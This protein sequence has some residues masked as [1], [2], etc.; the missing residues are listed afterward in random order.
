M[1]TSYLTNLILIVVVGLLYWLNA[2]EA[3]DGKTTTTLSQVSTKSIDNI[4][5]SQSKRDDIILA[6]QGE[7]WQLTHPI[8]THANPT[9]INLL[10]SLLSSHTYRQ[11]TVSEQ[12]N[13][14]QFGFNN[15]STRLQLADQL[16]VFGGVEPISQQR[17]LLHN[18]IIYLIEDTISPLL[19]TSASSFI[20][21]RLLPN[22]HITKL[23]LPLYQQQDIT[24]NTLTVSLSEGHW[25]SNPKHASGKLIS[26]VDSWQHA[27]ALQVIP[28]DTISEKLV[29]YVKHNVLIWL[30]NRTAPLQL[31]LYLSDNALFIVNTELKLAYQFPRMLYQQL[32]LTTVTNDA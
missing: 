9:R 25:K 30:E 19:N 14:E 1:K 15:N 20:D 22:S 28:F 13:L 4:I 31:T 5:I 7:V 16:F 11:Q 8:Q 6:K 26:L 21:N 24:N 23:T 32:L 18:D 17:Y 27:Y 10:L 3:E 12:Q 2:H 29:Q